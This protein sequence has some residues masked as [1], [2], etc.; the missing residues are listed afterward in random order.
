MAVAADNRS[1]RRRAM[2]WPQTLALVFG[3]VY[4]LVGIAGFFWTGFDAFA[5]HQHEAILGIFMVNPLHNVVHILVGLVGLA[6][7]RTLGGARAYGWLLF[8]GYGVVS[9]YGLL[10]VDHEWDFLD[11]NLADNMLHVATA[12]VG[13]ILALAPASDDRPRWAR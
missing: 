9:L 2:T 3:A 1:T 4:L 10:A 13:V 12:L 5:G 7:A 8:A 11:L 6:L